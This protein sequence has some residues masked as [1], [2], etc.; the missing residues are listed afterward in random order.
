MLGLQTIHTY[1]NYYITDMYNL[2]LPNSCS[3]FDFAF[4]NAD[5]GQLVIGIEDEK[6][7][8]SSQVS[9]MVDLIP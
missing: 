1:P 9:R 5:G 6:Q 3:A 2:Q 8:I 7:T 4:A